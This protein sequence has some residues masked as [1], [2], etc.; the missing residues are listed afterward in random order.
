MSYLSKNET[1]AK[2]NKCKSVRKFSDDIYGKAEI[3][4]KNNRSFDQLCGKHP[5][6]FSFNR[7]NENPETDNK[8]VL[9]IEEG[10]QYKIKANKLFQQNNY[11]ESLRYY[12]KVIF[13][14]NF[15]A[16]GI[17]TLNE[18][19]RKVYKATNLSSIYI[20]CLLNTAICSYLLRN[21]EEV[22]EITNKVTTSSE[23]R[24]LS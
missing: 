5:R 14:F 1:G 21:F 16:L 11:A 19:N 15:Q 10:I 6:N 13:E 12:R 2:I 8:V 7:L 20:E 22:I 23:N 17:F 18:K 24:Y 9:D 3:S 4:D